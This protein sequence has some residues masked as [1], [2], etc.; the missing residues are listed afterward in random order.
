MNDLKNKMVRTPMAPLETF[1]DDPLRVLRVVRFASRLGY[2]I[3][4]DIYA[5]VLNP[6]IR[7]A[8][9]EKISKERVGVEV[10]KMLTGADPV[11]YV[12]GC[13]FF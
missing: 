5:S 1:R 10:E 12:D 13:L 2:T 6:E 3:H 4:S 7:M 8:F 9:S 11:R